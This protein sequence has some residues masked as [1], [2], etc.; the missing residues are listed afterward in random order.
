MVLPGPK[1][2]RK[3]VIGVSLGPCRETCMP[4]SAGTCGGFS[5]L[6]IGLTAH[7]KSMATP[8]SSSKKF[9]IV[10]GVTLVSIFLVVWAYIAVPPFFVQ[11]G[12]H[13]LSGMDIFSISGILRCDP[14]EDFNNC[15]VTRETLVSAVVNDPHPKNWWPI[16]VEAFNFGE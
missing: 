2:H 14:P 11:M 3:P 9:L 12:K 4:V 1:R 10:S 8:T 13:Y 6:V 16:R 15:V 5:A 7:W